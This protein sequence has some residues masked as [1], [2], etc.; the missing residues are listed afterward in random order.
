MSE[1]RDSQPEPAQQGISLGELTEAFAQAMG[2]DPSETADEAATA[3]E[4]A[5]STVDEPADEGPSVESPSSAEGLPG[6]PIEEDDPCE[7]CPR[8]ILEAMLFVGNRR[9]EPISARQASELM[10]DVEPEEIDEL[11]RQINERYSADGCPY[12]VAREGAG[13]R[14]TLRKSLHPLRNRFYGRIREAKLSQ[15]AVDVLA[16]VAYKQ[17]LTTEQVN[18]L[19]GKSSGH[20]LSQLVR[21]GLLRIERPQ[22]EEPE[23]E[24]PEPKKAAPKRRQLATYFVTDRFLTLFGL[25]SV[26]DLPR[27]DE[28]DR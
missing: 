23:P 19:R 27:S 9:N 14:L 11:V 24:E 28:L 3:E 7:I 4:A 22:P 26:D 15:A 10:R 12:H 1:S 18:R 21:R 6:D 17:P 8:T 2:L 25:E 16:I 13:Y 5:L 20:I